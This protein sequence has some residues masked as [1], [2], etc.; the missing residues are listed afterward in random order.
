VIITLRS[1]DIQF[2][3]SLVK[4]YLLKKVGKVSNFHCG[5]KWG[6]QCGTDTDWKAW[7]AKARGMYPKLMK[8]SDF[9]EWID[10]SLGTIWSVCYLYPRGYIR[11][12]WI[13]KTHYI[14]TGL[15]KGGWYEPRTR[16]LHSIMSECVRYIEGC[17]DDDYQK[18]IL[19][20][21]RY[22]ENSS[23]CY[24]GSKEETEWYIATRDKLVP[25]CEAY[26]WWKEVYPT[27]A[28][29]E[30]AIYDKWPIFNKGTLTEAEDDNYADMIYKLEEEADKAEKENCCKVISCMEYMLD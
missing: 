4:N 30:K 1:E 22:G 16:L 23:G 24:T 3:E 8:I 11:C 21:V 26:I 25:L 18:H 27:Y 12:R 17:D 19:E 5:D 20:Y 14:E 28:I 9:C 15:K 6:F 7:E 10:N 2:F 13:S 29:R